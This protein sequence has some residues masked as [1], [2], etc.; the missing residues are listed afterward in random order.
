MLE[1]SL[2]SAVSCAV[3]YSFASM[4]LYTAVLANRFPLS[5][6]GVQS[7]ILNLASAVWEKYI[8][9]YIGWLDYT[10]ETGSLNFYP[11]LFICVD[12]LPLKIF[13]CCIT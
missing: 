2:N 5:K 7:P 10:F 8:L 11:K 1:H 12:D 9:K 6:H 13:I 4:D 3:S